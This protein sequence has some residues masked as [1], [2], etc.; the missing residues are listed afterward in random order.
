MIGYKSAARLRTVPLLALA[1]VMSGCAD[2]SNSPTGLAGAIDVSSFRPNASTSSIGQGT[3]TAHTSDGM[4]YTLDPVQSEIR[5]G[6]GSV[7]ALT[8]EQLAVASTAFR[9]TANGDIYSADAEAEWNSGGPCQP[10]TPGCYQDQS[11]P[12][13]TV[14]T[15]GVEPQATASR[16]AV[17]FSGV[18]N[19]SEYR[20]TRFGVMPGPLH[21]GIR[22]HVAAKRAALRSA[23]FQIASTPSCLEISQTMYNVSQ[24][25]RQSRGSYFNNLKSF[26][27]PD[28][29]IGVDATGRP[30][31]KVP[32]FAQKAIDADMLAHNELTDVTELQFLGA[33]YSAYGCWNNQWSDVTASGGFGSGTSLVYTCRAEIWEISYDGGVTWEP[34]QV[35][36]CEYQQAA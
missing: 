35:D 20:G 10:G 24:R 3:I 36:V 27:S 21:A 8:P 14:E 9:S 6:D 26:L 22:R 17:R 4:S 32:N 18:V 23:D 11:L 29:Y 16:I 19:G 25:Y 5:V 1:V 31:F 15:S 13:E 7:I 34:I 33:L 12:G 2:A 28:S 30:T